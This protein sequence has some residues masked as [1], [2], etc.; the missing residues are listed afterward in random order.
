MEQEEREQYVERV[1]MRG[2]KVPKKLEATIECDMF[3]VVDLSKDIPWAIT[4]VDDEEESNDMEQ[5]AEPKVEIPKVLL[6]CE[7]MKRLPPH[8]L[9]LKE[10]MKDQT[11]SYVDLLR[12]D[13]FLARLEE[14][15][16]P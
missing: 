3:E 16:V 10:W 14:K 12:P 1:R 13:L 7:R 5:E 15:P 11:I 8:R 4:E 2:E 9:L 6:S